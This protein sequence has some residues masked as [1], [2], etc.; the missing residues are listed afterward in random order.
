MIASEL[1][2]ATFSEFAIVSYSEESDNYNDLNEDQDYDGVAEPNEI[3]SQLFSLC[4]LKKGWDA[5]SGEEIGY[6]VV[7]KA[8]DL[9]STLLVFGLSC[10]VHPTSDGGVSLVFSC[11]DTF[12]D[13]TIEPDLTFSLV[14]EKGIGFD[15]TTI[16]ERENI[17]QGEIL[18][19]VRLLTIDNYV[20][21]SLSEPYIF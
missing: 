17:A 3:V 18:N 13:V 20:K 9:Y 15:Y 16:F 10:S 11:R 1:V 8:I 14:K 12:L 19:E 5:G 4:N 2:Y 6:M 21:C 7:E